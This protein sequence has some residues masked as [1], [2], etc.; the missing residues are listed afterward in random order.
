[1]KK[2][3]SRCDYIESRNSNLRREFLARL[4]RNGRT[5]KDVFRSLARESQAD[6]FYINEE[7]AYRLIRAGEGYISGRRRMLEDIRTRVD[8]LMRSDPSLSLK[9]AVY[10]TVNSPAPGFYLSEETIKTII[11][12]SRKNGK[13]NNSAKAVG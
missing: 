1:M 4:G 6:R 5:L 9:D 7:R 13:Y 10:I 8:S 12:K 2:K 3:N 11:Y